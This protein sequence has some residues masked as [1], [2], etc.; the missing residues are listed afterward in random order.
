MMQ[1]GAHNRDGN[2]VYMFRWSILFGVPSK[3]SAKLEVNV[4][5]PIHLDVW[6]LHPFVRLAHSL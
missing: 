2:R 5:V 1:D 6:G 3:L 4:S